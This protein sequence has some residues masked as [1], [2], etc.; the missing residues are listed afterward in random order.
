MILEKSLVYKLFTGGVKQLGDPQAEDKLERPWESGIF[1]EETEDAVFLSETGFTGDDVADKR[2]HGGPEKAVFAYSVKHYED[3]RRELDA[4]IGPGGNGENLSVT[5]MDETT[6][7]IGDTYRL[8]EALIQVSQPRRPCWKP[9]RRHKI[10]DLALRIQKTGRTGWY[11]RV[12]E[13]G[14]IR[15]GDAFERVSRPYPEWTIRACNEVMHEQKDNLGLAESLA[16]CSLLAKNWKNTLDKRLTGKEGGIDKRVYG[17][18][19]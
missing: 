9:A 5:G 6:V 13:E 19:R 11:F 10:L 4:D 15:S 18:N 12:L 17:P 7:C 2:N 14:K 3:W 1:K 8:G 16:A